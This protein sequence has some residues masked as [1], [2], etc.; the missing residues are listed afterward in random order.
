MGRPMA[1]SQDFVNWICSNDVDPQF[2]AYLLIAENRSLFRFASGATHQTIYYPEVKAFHVCIPPSAEQTRIV[3]ILDKAFAG[4][5]TAIA[6]TEKNLANARELYDRYL[7]SVFKN[8]SRSWTTRNLGDCFR[9]KSG[10]GLTSQEMKEGGDFP[11]FGGNGVAGSHT[12][13]NLCGDNVIIGRVGALCGNVR[14]ITQKIWL[15]DNAF[16]VTDFSTKF[17]NRFLTYL[18]NYKNLRSLARQSAQPVISNSSLK[19]LQLE[20]PVSVTDQQRIAASFDALSVEAKRLD[21]ICRQKLIAL[22]ELKQSIL[23][24]AFAGKLTAHPEKALPEAAE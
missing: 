21:T 5:D 18:L 9:L 7:N 20:F 12:K 6:N 19:D 13:Y 16:R 24:R 1:T 15:T 3:A 17:D 14:H 2:L 4:I 22:A 8:T 11:V 10:D 23:H